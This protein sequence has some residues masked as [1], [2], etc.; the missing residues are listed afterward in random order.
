MIKLKKLISMVAGISMLACSLVSCGNPSAP[1]KP[2]DVKD[3]VTQSDLDLDASKPESSWEFKTYSLDKYAGEDVKITLSCNVEAESNE[4]EPVTFKWQVNQGS[5]YPEVVTFDVAPGKSTIPVSGSNEELITLKKGDLLYLSTNNATYDIKMKITDLKYSVEYTTTTGGDDE[6]PPVSYPTDI[7]KVGEAGTCGIKIGDKDL[8]PF[9]DALKF[10]T[11]ATEIKYN[12]D[13]SVTYIASA[14]GGAGGGIAF[15]FDENQ[16]VLNTANYDSVDVELTYSPVTGS[17]NKDATKVGFCLRLLTFDS[18]GIFGG[19]VDAE[20]FDGAEMYGD[21]NKNIDFATNKVTA[22]VVDSADFDGIKAFVIK[23]ND[24]QR[25]N[26]DGDKLMVQLKKVTFNRKAGAPEDKPYDDGLKP[27]QRGTVTSVEYPTKDYAALARGEEPETYNKHAWVYTPAGY[28][29]KDTAK[30][31][32]VFVLLH[33]FGQNENTWGLSDKGSGGKI[34]GYMDRGMAEGKVEPF[35]LICVTGVASKNWGPNGSGS[36]FEG[37]NA[38]SPE[39]RDDILPWVYANY[40]CIEDRDHTALAGLSMGG[41]QTFNNGLKDNLDK[42]SYFGAFSAA[43]FT[44]ADTYKTDVETKWKNNPELKA[45]Y[46]YMICGDADTTVYG[47]YPAFVAA[48][49]DKAW[50]ERIEKFSETTVP[51]GT[52]DFPVWFKGFNEFITYVFK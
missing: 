50:P 38:F 31:Y 48:F 36:D 35:I 30:K 33:G 8:I 4:T 34:K 13:G 16:S 41:G 26:T 40:N 51:G 10:D 27:E 43:V 21:L 15:Y 2:K 9:S 7:F 6:E 18:T 24:Y 14:A 25:G 46:L 37:F 44:D 49:N 17:W 32:P 23:F 29:P 42:I 45:H 12:A 19:A 28:D 22:S 1:G 3:D 20:Y 5:A 11:V 52:H 47:S 39:L